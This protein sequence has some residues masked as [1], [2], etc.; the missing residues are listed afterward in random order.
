MVLI[1][2]IKKTRIEGFVQTPL[3]TSLELS[4]Y[5]K[6]SDSR[7]RSCNKSSLFRN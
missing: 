3:S 1:Y 4:Y 6:I 2:I 5:L 7:A